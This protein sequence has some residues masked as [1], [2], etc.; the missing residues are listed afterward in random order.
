MFFFKKT[1]GNYYSFTLK[2]DKF[3]FFFQK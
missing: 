3:P 2:N 1:T